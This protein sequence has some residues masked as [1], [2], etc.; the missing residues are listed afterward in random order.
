MNRM[1]MT[2][3]SMKRKRGVSMLETMV[4]IG[5]MTLMLGVITSIFILNYDIVQKQSGR[6]NTDTG[7]TLAVKTITELA[8]GATAVVTT[9]TVIGGTSY[10][11]S[12]TVL[13]I[14]APS[15][16]ASKNIIAGQFDFIALYRHP[17][18]TTKI[19][20]VAALGLGSTRP[21][22][23]HLITAYNQ[24]MYF[25]FNNPDPALADRVSVY[26]VNQQTVKGA[27]LTTKAWNSIFLRN[28]E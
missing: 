16:D 17:T 22:A 5:I 10:T 6:I 12:S 26:L 23:A 24:T 13:V 7:A 18:E 1:H 25:R 27:T 28:Y 4:V 2:T 19:F 3:A 9:P 20:S 15:L 21:S 11:T 8:R 14:R